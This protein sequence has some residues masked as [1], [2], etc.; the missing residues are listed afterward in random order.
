MKHKDMDILQDMPQ[1]KKMPFSTPEGYFDALKSDL[2]KKDVIH[3]SPWKRLSPY[4]AT[5]AV[6]L[7]LVSAGT[8]ILQKATPQDGMTQEDYILFSDEMTNTIDYLH[9]PQQIAD[10]EV[11]DEDIINYLIY[12]GTTVEEV[13]LSK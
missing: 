13:E 1:L 11:M 12:T 4:A 8:F 6:F 7:F 2:R 9:S 5:A 3:V 10:A